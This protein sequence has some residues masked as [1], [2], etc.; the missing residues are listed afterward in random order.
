MHSLGVPPTKEQVLPI[1]SDPMSFILNWGKNIVEKLKKIGFADENIILDPGVGFGKTSYQNL[2]I[3][4]R[5][6]ALKS[7]GVQ[8]MIGHSRKGYINSFSNYSADC[9]DIET[10]AVSSFIE[11]SVEYIRIHNVRDHMRSLVAKKVLLNK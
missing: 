9:R 3:L 6:V 5:T 4:R 2:E 11:E 10:I 8:I 1:E 7:L